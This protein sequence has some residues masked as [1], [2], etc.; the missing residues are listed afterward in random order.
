TPFNTAALTTDKYATS[1]LL[2]NKS[3]TPTN[4]G[5]FT[6]STVFANFPN[7]WTTTNG[8]GTF[9]FLVKGKNIG[10]LYLKTIDGKSGKFDIYVDGVKTQ[11][12]NA[13]FTG[14][15][16]NYATA[17]EFWSS[18]VSTQHTIEIKLTDG[19]TATGLT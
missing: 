3:L 17:E 13:D 9:N 1:M 7:S 6:T 15:F 2:D 16:G 12:I 11:T 5:S 10:L 14:G 18:D 4:F 19:S 8:T